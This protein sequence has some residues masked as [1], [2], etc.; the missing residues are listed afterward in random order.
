MPLLTEM[1]RRVL[2]GNPYPYALIRI[3]YR[4]VG[5]RS[6][7]CSPGFLE[8]FFSETELPVWVLLGNWASAKYH[9]RKL[10]FQ[11]TQF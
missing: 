3:H 11:H 8:E 5:K 6:F 10:S 9:S 1:P 4:G 2:L 7:A